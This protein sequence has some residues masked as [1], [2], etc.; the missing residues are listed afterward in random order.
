VLEGRPM[1]FTAFVSSDVKVHP[2]RTEDAEEFTMRHVGEMLTPPYNADRLEELGEWSSKTFTAE[3]QG[4]KRAA[5]D[6]V[7]S[8]LG[9]VSVTGAGNCRLRVCTP[10]GVGVFTRDALMPFEVKTSGVGK[11]T[12]TRTINVR[13]ANKAA[14]A[15]KRRRY[16][17]EDGDYF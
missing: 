11:Y 5:L 15:K 2:G 12:G 16:T 4:W 1:F 7:L 14:R 8:G 10:K 9:W 13:E 17:Q 6:V 3:G